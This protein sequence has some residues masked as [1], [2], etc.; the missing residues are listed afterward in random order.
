MNY[1]PKRRRIK[2]A[3]ITFFALFFSSPVVA[4][5]TCGACDAVPTSL[6]DDA[7]IFR[8]NIEAADVAPAEILQRQF[9]GTL[10]EHFSCGQLAEEQA[11]RFIDRLNTSKQQERDS[12]R[13]DINTWLAAGAFLVGLFG[14]LISLFALFRVSNKG[15]ST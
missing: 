6:E 2:L 10:C 12:K 9:S 8:Q 13:A 7:R 5:T 1:F 4:Q 14:L 11:S 15:V 3:W